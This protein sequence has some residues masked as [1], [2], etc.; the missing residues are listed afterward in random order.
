MMKYSEKESGTKSLKEGAW[1]NRLVG[2]SL[3]RSVQQPGPL[4]C[5]SPRGETVLALE[6]PD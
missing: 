2:E 5:S 4:F 6:D 1:L 3:P